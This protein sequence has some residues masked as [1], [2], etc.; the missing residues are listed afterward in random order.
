MTVVHHYE[1]KGK[2]R[3]TIDMARRMSWAHL[4]LW[5]Y[6][7]YGNS[8]RERT[9]LQLILMRLKGAKKLTG[10]T[11]MPDGKDGKLPQNVDWETGIAYIEGNAPR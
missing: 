7:S 1:V 4:R 10:E 8:A 9:I 5:S 6:S 11:A 2:H 3:I